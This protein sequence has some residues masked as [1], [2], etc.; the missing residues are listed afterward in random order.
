ME[1][2]LRRIDPSQDT[3]VLARCKYIVEQYEKTL[4]AAGIPFL[5]L[6]AK[7]ETIPLRAAKALWDLQH[8]KPV[9]GDDFQC[10]MKTIH[11]TGNLARGAKAMWDRETTIQH[12]SVVPPSRLEEAGFKESMIEKVRSGEWSEMHSGFRRWHRAA[13][14]HGPELASSPAVRTGTIHSA[15]GM[16]ADVVVLSTTVSKNIYESQ[17]IDRERHDEERR[18]EYVGITRARRR[19]ILTTEDRAE[20]KMRIQ[21]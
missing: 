8:G 21:A 12:F 11:A 19:L 3:L 6:K 13:K 9:T 10:V 14:A 18:V 20:Y 4:V 15:K 16:E 1:Q 7:G 5:Q 17:S 2:T